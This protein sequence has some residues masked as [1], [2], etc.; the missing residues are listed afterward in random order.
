MKTIIATCLMMGLFTLSMRAQSACEINDVH[1]N[2]D[3]QY[4]KPAAASAAEPYHTNQF[5]WIR[6]WWPIAW[7]DVPMGSVDPPPPQGANYMHI[8]S[9]FYSNDLDL[10]YFAKH[11]SSDFQPRD[12]WELVA[13]DFGMEYNSETTV[14]PSNDFSEGYLILYNKHTSTL[15][16]LVTP[17]A[18]NSA[19]NMA[20]MR[21]RLEP[22]ID[23]HA[24]GL[25]AGT[26]GLL[27]PLDQP[28]PTRT[29]STRFRSTNMPG[30]WFHGD[31][32]VFYDPCSCTRDQRLET[33]HSVIT[34]G[35]IRLYGLYAGTV[36]KLDAFWDL[37]Y[38]PYQRGVIKDPGAYLMSLNAQNRA[39]LR[40]G[41]IVAKDN[42]ALVQS[43]DLWV[44]ERNNRNTG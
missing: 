13:Y 4:V 32:P 20:E 12:G 10:R 17:L 26:G 14:R 18:V 29:V 27:N 21:W 2:P 19:V 41:A 30:R 36:S 5:D 6:G 43:Y 33:R 25:F 38:V 35:E 11:A 28:S 1:T 3:P 44:S 23:D 42:A 40:P 16:A 8:I 37:R 22:R 34:N 15:R 39:D 24:S 7:K 31:V 9:P